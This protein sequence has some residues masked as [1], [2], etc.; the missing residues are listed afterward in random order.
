MSMNL[1]FSTMS[2]TSEDS[3]YALQKLS[4]AVK[5][6]ELLLNSDWPYDDSR[7]A[8][9]EIHKVFKRQLEEM[10]GL[11]GASKEIQVSWCRN[12]R[13]RL[14][15]LIGFVGVIMRSA[16]VRNSFESYY[17]IRTLCD[18]LL[19]REFGI[20]LG[21]EWSYSPF[22]YP[23]PN[24]TLK[25][26][27]FFGLPS[28]E[29]QNALLVP[30]A[31]HELGHALWRMGNHSEAVVEKITSIKQTLVDIIKRR[32]RE[33]PSQA[34]LFPEYGPATPGPTEIQQYTSNRPIFELASRQV[35]EVFCDV[36]GC[37]IFGDSFVHAYCYLMSPDDGY[38]QSSYYP[39][40]RARAEFISVAMQEFYQK[41]T[42][43]LDRFPV[44]SGDGRQ[45]SNKDVISADTI[46]KDMFKYVLDAVKFIMEKVKIER[47]KLDAEDAAYSSLLRIGPSMSGTPQE[48]I[49][50]GWRLRRNINSWSVPGVPAE[51]KVAILNDLIFKSFEV[52]E[53]I[54]REELKIKQKRKGRRG[55]K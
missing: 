6:T 55:V 42:D 18:N 11:S 15:E 36:V 51:K 25:K 13:S 17:P 45:E 46:T 12:T 41:K 1:V 54:K 24:E 35:E 28:T 22:V 27:I 33:D 37:W 38:R 34:V 29:S 31:G 50:A 20:I 47:P 5:L 32:P 23:I 43:I 14:K 30:V 53:F 4:S 44:I 26:Y 16:E 21:S 8:L 19:G 7:K 9:D 48:V 2:T 52:S 40:N 3:E 10:S 49:N 39:T